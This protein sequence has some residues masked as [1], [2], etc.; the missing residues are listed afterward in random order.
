[1]PREAR[2]PSSFYSATNYL[3]PL[4]RKRLRAI[5]NEP[6]PTETKTAKTAS[7]RTSKKS[8]PKRRDNVGKTQPPAKRKRSTSDSSRVAKAKSSRQQ[9]PVAAG[10]AASADGKTLVIPLSLNPTAVPA[11]APDSSVHSEPP[12]KKSRKFFS[13]GL[14]APANMA[15]SWNNKVK[16][17]VQPA[18][19]SLE[20]LP[21]RKEL[22]MTVPFRPP[23]M[24]AE[25]ATSIKNV[26]TAS[27]KL[28]SEKAKGESAEMRDEKHAK[29]SMEVPRKPSNNTSARSVPEVQDTEDARTRTESDGHVSPIGVETDD[30]EEV[31]H[32]LS[33]ACEPCS[34]VGDHDETGENHNSSMEGDVQASRTE[35]ERSIA[36][37]E[38]EANQSRS[39]EALCP[40]IPDSPS[41]RNLLERPSTPPTGRTGSPNKQSLYPIF[42]TPTSKCKKSTKL[43]DIPTSPIEVPKKRFM[44]GSS[45]PAQ[46]II[47]AGQKKFGHTMCPTC[48]MVYTIGDADDEKLHVKHHRTFLAVM[49]FPGWKNQREVGLYPDGKVIMV[50]PN[51]PKNMLN[52]MDEI[53]QMVDRELGI[54][55]DGSAPRVPQMYFV[56]VSYT[57]TVLGFLSAQEIKQ[58]YRMIPGENGQSGYCCEVNPTPAVCGVSRIWTAPFYRRKKV[59]SRLLDRLRMNFSFGC[60]IESRKIA[61]SDPT[62]MGRELAAAYTRNDRFLV[63]CP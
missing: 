49:K 26:G 54:L 21:T 33:S 32:E 30:L 40:N 41:R 52:K 3:S 31:V 5:E 18:I 53:R 11:D 44:P 13:S 62:L 14:R 27:P 36:H 6:P 2:T 56:F 29:S 45:D 57:K 47:D 61:F 4:E 10:K 37:L 22:V 1:M 48:G 42:S 60:P 55:V 17:K 9:R 8:A 12:A 24:T 34:R 59:A 16:L 28:G 35:L 58:G 46:L 43:Q 25:A 50:S 20:H 19:A 23:N 39:V 15:V 63:F 7:K 38:A 51:D